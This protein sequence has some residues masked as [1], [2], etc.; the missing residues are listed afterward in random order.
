MAEFH[1]FDRV[2]DDRQGLQAQEIH[3]EQAG[4]FRHRVVE[5]RA[6][7]RAVLGGRNRHEVG[8]VVGGDDDPT[9]VDAC[10]SNA[11]FEDP[12][13]L[14]RLT[15]QSRLGADGLQLLHHGEALAPHLLLQRLV[16]QAEHLLEGDVRNELGEAVRVTQRQFHDARRVA[17]GRLGGHGPV[18]DDLGHLVGAILVDHIVNDP[19]TPLVVKVN[20][21]IGETDTVWVQEPLEQQVVLDGVDVGDADAVRHS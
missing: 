3:L 18:G 12:R 19:A 5:L 16:V 10:V 7:H 15:L 11:A 17:N 6:R 9:G 20:V 2:L 13:S 1:I 21:D 4:V 14:E 8:D